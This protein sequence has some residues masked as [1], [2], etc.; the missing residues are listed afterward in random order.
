MSFHLFPILLNPI[1]V[2]GG[3]GVGGVWY[4]W[5]RGRTDLD[6]S[7][8]GLDR[9]KHPFTLTHR[10]NLESSIK[11]TCMWEETD[12]PGEIPNVRRASTWTPKYQKG[13]TDNLF[14]RKKANWD[15]IFYLKVL[16]LG[17]ALFKSPS[18]TK[19]HFP[20][21]HADFWVNEVALH[22]SSL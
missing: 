5:M 7:I 19:I 1:Q 8:T 3:G 15:N 4:H 20:F 16:L 12:A 14:I 21:L 10:V 22:L 17:E 2:R 9:D 18:Q 13:I 11:L 6:R